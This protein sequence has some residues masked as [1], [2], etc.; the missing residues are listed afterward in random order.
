MSVRATMLVRCDVCFA[1]HPPNRAIRGSRSAA[2]AS[3]PRMHHGTRRGRRRSCGGY[4]RARKTAAADFCPASACGQLRRGGGRRFCR[5]WAWHH[6]GDV[7]SGRGGGCRRQVGRAALATRAPP[8]PVHL[9]L[10]SARPQR[11]S[12]ESLSPSAAPPL[13]HNLRDSGDRDRWQ[14]FQRAIEPSI[15][16]RS[17]S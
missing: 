11:Q 8:I 7:V 17:V 2:H 16:E 5:R 13:R 12:S 15:S 10:P 14:R 4:V 6:A 1:L 3:R 9:V